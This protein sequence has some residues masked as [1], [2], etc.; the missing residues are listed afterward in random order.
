M[1][2]GKPVPAA[3]LVNAGHWLGPFTLGTWRKLA[4]FRAASERMLE[5]MLVLKADLQPGKKIDV[6]LLAAMPA[7]EQML[8]EDL[9]RLNL[10]PWPRK[11]D[12]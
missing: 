5:A 8:R 12:P 10:L 7:V 6:A 11:L 2:A 3:E 1:R 4:D 9:A